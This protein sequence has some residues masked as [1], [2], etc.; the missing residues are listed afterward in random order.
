MSKWVIIFKILQFLQMILFATMYA[1]IY[2][3]FK[4]LLR[5]YKFYRCMPNSYIYP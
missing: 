3:D 2:Q 4:I 5:I 1:K